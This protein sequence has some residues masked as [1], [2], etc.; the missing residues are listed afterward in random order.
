MLQVVINYRNTL[1]HAYI[2]EYFQEMMQVKL[3]IFLYVTG[4]WPEKDFFM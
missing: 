3:D 1:L 4:H 2:S